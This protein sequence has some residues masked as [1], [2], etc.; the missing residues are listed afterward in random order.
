MNEILRLA[1]PYNELDQLHPHPIQLDRLSLSNTENLFEY[2]FQ[3]QQGPEKRQCISATKVDCH[4]Q[5]P[6]NEPLRYIDNTSATKTTST[7]LLVQCNPQF[8]NM[9][10][11]LLF[12]VKNDV[13]LIIVKTKNDEFTVSDMQSYLTTQAPETKNPQVEISKITYNSEDPKVNITD[14]FDPFTFNN[15]I[16]NVIVFRVEEGKYQHCFDFKLWICPQDSKQNPEPEKR[17][18]PE[19]QVGDYRSAF[20]FILDDGPEFRNVLQK[21]EQR[22]PTIQRNTA[23]LVEE[24]KY[25]EGNLNRLINNKNKII[26]LI[27]TF[28][29]LNP[30]LAKFKFKSHFKNTLN[31][32]VTPLEANL[33]FFFN[34]VCQKKLLDKISQVSSFDDEKSELNLLKKNFDSQSNSYYNWLK[35]YLSNEKER[36]ELK[37]LL[38]RRIFE[39]SKFDYLNYL[40]NFTNNQYV[41]ELLENL[42]KFT[43]MNFNV[44]PNDTPLNI[45][46]VG[47]NNYYKIYLGVLLKYNSEKF[48]LRQMIETCQTND[49]LTNLVRFNNL[50]AESKIDDNTV[51]TQDNLD[52]MFSPVT[53]VDEVAS[54]TSPVTD[55]AEKSG[56]LYTLGGKGKQGWH[57][58]WVVIKEGELREFS[59]WR[60][61]SGPMKNSIQIALSNIKPTSHDKRQYCFEIFT[62]AGNKYTFQAINENERDDWIKVLNK[63]KL[64][65][66]PDRLKETYKGEKSQP[67]D[68]SKLKKLHLKLDK[69]HL[70]VNV[71][72]ELFSPVSVKSNPIISKD[73]L[74]TVRSIPDSNNHVCADCEGTESV[75]WISINFLVI[76]C[77]NCSSHHRNLGSHISKVRSLKLDNFH[78]K[79]TEILLNYINNKSRNQILESTSHID[80]TKISDKDRLQYI[81]DKYQNKKY[82][83][84]PENLMELLIKAVQSV[85]LEDTIKCIIQGADPNIVIHSKSFK[86]PVSLFVYSLRKNLD[87]DAHEGVNKY[88][89]ITEFLVLNGC[90]IPKYAENPELSPEALAYWTKKYSRIS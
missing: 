17:P 18:E 31:S 71:N 60:T 80:K 3:F 37:L 38:K 47:L 20:N 84:S 35:K 68:T 46:K 78:D 29:S 9:G 24:L 39:L 15:G 49:E 19:I 5:Q 83:P 42:F 62:N 11:H 36:P 63:S 13:S 22:I 30:I 21:Y 54:P 32:L 67:K 8:N 25:M 52:M 81:K 44:K 4:S 82:T 79:E 72:H 74:T 53:P 73:Y 43:S 28:S 12:P 77:I 75:E 27:Y 70:S 66:D 57:K 59:D 41:N 87:I 89:V 33:R 55:Q 56:I 40:N 61:G 6:I 64:L 10:L 14:S 48:K 69:P 50:T 51:V 34:D 88:F 23:I 85:S 86:E 65:I 16:M 58:E 1:F 7:P 2:N 90:K 26:E 45:N 76:L